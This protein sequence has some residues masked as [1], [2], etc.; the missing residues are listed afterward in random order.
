VWVVDD[1]I[2]RSGKVYRRVRD[3]IEAL[4]LG[5]LKELNG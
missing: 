5:L 4:V 1:P 3:E 2:G